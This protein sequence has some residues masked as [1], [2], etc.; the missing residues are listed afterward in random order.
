M[1]ASLRT[2]GAYPFTWRASR[3]IASGVAL[4]EGEDKDSLLTMLL[5]S[6][7]LVGDST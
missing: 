6:L 3:A 2:R 7:F 1:G 4:G 5:L